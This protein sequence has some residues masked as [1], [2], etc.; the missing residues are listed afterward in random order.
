MNELGEF[1]VPDPPDR[2][3]KRLEA[4]R[5]CVEVDPS[6]FNGDADAVKKQPCEPKGARKRVCKWCGAEYEAK[7]PKQMYCSK[8]CGRAAY[9]ENRKKSRNHA[10][11]AGK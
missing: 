7:T 2:D 10:K 3:L 5:S 1:V 4:Y 11:G 6:K 9:N 8:T